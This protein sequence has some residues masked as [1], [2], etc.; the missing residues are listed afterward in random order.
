ML[1]KRPQ[2][3]LD[4]G[5]TSSSEPPGSTSTPAAGR[6]QVPTMLSI[7]FPMGGGPTKSGHGLWPTR[8]ID[9]WRQT[10]SGSAAPHRR[11]TGCSRGP[12]PSGSVPTSRLSKR[13]RTGP[14]DSAVASSARPGLPHPRLDGGGCRHMPR[15]LRLPGSSP[16][17]VRRR[18]TRTPVSR[19]QA[20]V[21]AGRFACSTAQS[22]A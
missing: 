20:E 13:G 16:N 6:L 9:G 14:A 5:P 8:H 11:E 4:T 18:P 21:V 10:C 2:R 17:V 15:T 12:T 1:A 3:E 7:T 22:S 19:A